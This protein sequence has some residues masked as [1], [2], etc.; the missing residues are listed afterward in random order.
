MRMIRNFLSIGYVCVLLAGAYAQPPTLEPNNPD[1]EVVPTLTFERVYPNETAA[2]YAISVDS[3]GIAAYQ[4]EGLGPGTR[5]EIATG[6]PYILK[7][8]ISETTSMRIFRLA[9]QANYF[10]RDSSANSVP[11]TGDITLTYEEGPPDSFGHLT[12]SV[13]NSV[14]YNDPTTPVIRQLTIIFEGISNSIQLGRQLEYLRGTSKS[15][16]DF[17]LKRAEDRAR[18]HRLIE[19]QVIVP[20]LKEVAEDP[21]VSNVARRRAQHLLMLAQS[22]PAQ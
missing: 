14:T 18:A 6:E 9:R 5:Q 17:A 16:L 19:L 12:N 10:K 15:A 13:R 21:S 4:S 11:D 8:T 22:S 20:S 7:F 1:V 2:H 3:T